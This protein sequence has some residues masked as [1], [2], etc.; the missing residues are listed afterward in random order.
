MKRYVYTA[1]W[2]DSCQY[3]SDCEGEQI[4]IALFT[5][6]ANKKLL[7]NRFY[8]IRETFGTIFPYYDAAVIVHSE[9]YLL[10][11]EGC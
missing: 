9:T 7:K 6:A 4:Q 5:G 10:I 11:T 8:D 1:C 3:F 2:M